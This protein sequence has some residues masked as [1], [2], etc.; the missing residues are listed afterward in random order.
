LL[1]LRNSLSAVMVFPGVMV[2]AGRPNG[3][4]SGRFRNRHAPHAWNGH[5]PDQPSRACR[6]R[7]C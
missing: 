6:R 4:L 2:F 3:I 5:G 7:R 1:T